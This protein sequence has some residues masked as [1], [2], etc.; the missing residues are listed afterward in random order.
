MLDT[1]LR[2]QAGMHLLL[3]ALDA[4]PA[5]LA[6]K[7][8]SLSSLVNDKKLSKITQC[9]IQLPKLDLLQK[10]RQYQRLQLNVK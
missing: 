4:E 1:S 2:K 9:T 8:G 10:V 7:I 3:I 5:K 6:S